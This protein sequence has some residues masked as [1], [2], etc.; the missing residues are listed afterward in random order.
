MWGYERINSRSAPADD[1]GGLFF[2]E[3]A[4]EV[5]GGD[6]GADG[7]GA[8][9]GAADLDDERDGAVGRHRGEPGEE[10]RLA[11]DPGG[12]ELAGRISAADGG[13]FLGQFDGDVDRPG[14]AGPGVAERD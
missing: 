10:E 11:V 2:A 5:G 4:G 8:A 13:E 1:A 7:G 3:R 14:G 9:G 12:A 6:A